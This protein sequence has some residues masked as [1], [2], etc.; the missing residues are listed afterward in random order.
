MKKLLRSEKGAS[1][2]LVILMLVVLVVFGVAALTTA[3]SSVR[4][5][6]KVEDWNEKYY[7]AEAQANEMYAE[8]DKA[9]TTGVMS[10]LL[11]SKYPPPERIPDYVDDLVFDVEINKT[12][13]GYNFTYE[14]WQDDVGITVTLAY[15]KKTMTLS[16]AGWKQVQRD[17]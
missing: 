15:D 10:Q 17:K 1:S 16:P 3:L 14:S 5:G 13:Q 4:L 6:Q 7:T 11:S 12:S 9:V 2:V 8:I